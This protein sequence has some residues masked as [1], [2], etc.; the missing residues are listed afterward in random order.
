MPS[1][2][3][4]EPGNYAKINSGGS[5]AAL[6]EIDGVIPEDTLIVTKF[7]FSQKSRVQYKSALGGDI[8]VYPLGNEMGTVKVS[9]IAAYKLCD[10]E[11]GEGF[12]K[13]AE[14]YE[15]KKASLVENI[16]QP[17]KVTL[18]GLSNFTEKCYLES[19]AIVGSD[20]VNRIFGF[21]I[22][23]RVAPKGA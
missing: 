2:F 6:I 8:Y 22:V 15:Q 11:V 10:G 20:P 14:F 7:A 1:L 17:V 21:D 12:T 18:P 9:G 4:S 13:L 19:L 3:P 16:Q 23:F 5:G